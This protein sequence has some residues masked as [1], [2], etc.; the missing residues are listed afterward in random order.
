ML[1]L[2]EYTWAKDK[3][4][5]DHRTIH[6]ASANRQIDAVYTMHKNIKTDIANIYFWCDNTSIHQTPGNYSGH[7]LDGT[8]TEYYFPGNNLCS[9]GEYRNG[10]KTGI[11]ISWLENGKLKETSYWK[12][13][14]LTDERC[15][16]DES[17]KI[18]RTENYKNGLLNG[19]VIEI[20]KDTPVYTNYRNGLLKLRTPEIK[21]D[22]IKS[23]PKSGKVQATPGKNLLNRTW[24]KIKNVFSFL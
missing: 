1:I 24:D 23:T 4:I 16:Y 14:K 13:G 2:S 6:I 21:K 22:S 9:K 10:L 20:T 3:Y 5:S 12:K 18:V 8:Y 19:N 7:L 15:I 11:W 17:G